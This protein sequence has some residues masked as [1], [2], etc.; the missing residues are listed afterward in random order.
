MLLK[1]F[2]VMKNKEKSGDLSKLLEELKRCG[3]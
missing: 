1:I 2:K 3:N